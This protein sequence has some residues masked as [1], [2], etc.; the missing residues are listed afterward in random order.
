MKNKT[1]I[2]III[3]TALFNICLFCHINKNVLD[4]M[5]YDKTVISFGIYEQSM[6]EAEFINKVQLFSEDYDVEIAQYSYLNSNDVVIYSTKK[7]DYNDVLLLFQKIYNRCIKV[8]DFDKVLTVGLKNNIYVNTNDNNIIQAFINEFQNDCELYYTESPYKGEGFV[9][10]LI[11]LVD[12]LSVAIFILFAFIILLIFFSHYLET[13]KTTIIYNMWGYKNTYIYSLIN[14]EIFASILITDVIFGLFLTGYIYHFAITNITIY[15]YKWLFLYNI[16][17]FIMIVC[18]SYFMYS[19]MFFHAIKNRKKSISKFTRIFYFLKIVL[20]IILFTFIN[21]FLEEKMVLEEKRS[22]LDSWENTQGLFYINE[23][24]NPSLFLNLA[25]EKNY[26]DKI[27]KVYKYLADDNKVFII[28]TNNF[29]HSLEKNISTDIDDYV[30]KNN[31]QCEDDFFSP[32]GNNITVDMNYLKRHTVKGL[33]NENILESLVDN[34][35]ILNVLVP[36]KYKDKEETIIKSYQEWF[37]FYAVEVENMY[38]EESKDPLVTKDI[39]DLKIHIIY[40]EDN[41]E[42]FTYNTYTGNR[43]N[44]IVDPLIMVYTGNINN[45]FLGACLSGYMIFESSSQYDALNEMKQITS[46]YNVN[47]LNNI[48]SVYDQKGEEINR[49]KDNIR[50]IQ[51]CFIVIVLLICIMTI[52][53]WTGFCMNYYDEIICKSLFGHRYVSIFK[54]LILNN[55]IIN[56]SV[57]CFVSL[58]YRKIIPYIVIV[59][60]ILMALDYLFT[61]FISGI[62][63][64]KGNVRLI[65]GDFK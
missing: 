59:G 61:K 11:P 27:Y 38:R 15:I 28:N 13:K 3:L 16:F 6:D 39:D 14:K 56:M 42:I 52:I 62:L 41:Q 50:T 32:Y 30:Y 36:E 49:I 20:L 57:I 58:L 26:N 23:S 45:S 29:Q 63:I 65:K 24:N 40:I 64:M 46:K 55:W 21:Y 18:L 22:N 48:T 1:V 19:K 44:R 2:M 43:K 37:Y 51:K 4:R 35:N 10:Q 60:F 47:E 8:Y 53:V 25:V 34:E 54:R 5:L 12:F 33:D 17:V 31:V 7:D 9:S